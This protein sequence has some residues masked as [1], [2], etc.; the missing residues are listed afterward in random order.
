MIYCNTVRQWLL[1]YWPWLTC[2]THQCALHAAV[3]QDEEGSEDENEYQVDG[4]VVPEG[5]DDEGRKSG[6][7]RK[8]KVH[9]RLRRVRDVSGPVSTL[10]LLL[11]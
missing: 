1:E 10:C 11:H 7:R 2:C 8:K 4:F 3:L 5:E 9:K 6:K